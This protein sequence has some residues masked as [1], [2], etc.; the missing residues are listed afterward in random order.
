MKP[1]IELDILVAEKVMGIEDVCKCKDEFRPVTLGYDENMKFFSG[2]EKCHKLIAKRYSTDIAA[3][4]EVVEKLDKLGF[5]DVNIWKD[6]FGYI[7]QIQKITSVYKKFFDSAL[8]KTAPH[9]ICL[10]ALKA[11]GVEV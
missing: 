11:V 7:C 5:K 2:H 10:A 4:W 6:D 8:A 1:G 9:S 3:A